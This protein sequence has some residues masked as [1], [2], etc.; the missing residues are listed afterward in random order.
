MAPW[1]YPIQLSLSPLVSAVAAGNTV[2]LKPSEASP[3]SEKLIARLIEESF[4]PEHVTVIRGDSKTAE[5][6]LEQSFDFIFFTGSTK[7]GHIVA[8]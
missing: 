2:V 7:I 3:N 8:Q 4:P 5:E 6:L 1:N